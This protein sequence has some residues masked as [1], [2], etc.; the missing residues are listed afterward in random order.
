MAAH[1]RWADGHFTTHQPLPGAAGHR[2]PSGADRRGQGCDVARLLFELRVAFRH[3]ADIAALLWFFLMVITLFPLSVGSQPQLLARIAQPASSVAALLASLL[4]LERL[5]GATTCRTAAP[6]QLMLLP[7]P[8]RRGGAA[9]ESG[10]LGVTGLP[11]IMLSPL[12]RW[13]WT[14]TAE[15]S[16]R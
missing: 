4:A 14:C 3:G 8:R 2:P 9:G 13:G 10:P 16:W 12:K 7:V 5:L 1:A 15:K 11:P 6:E